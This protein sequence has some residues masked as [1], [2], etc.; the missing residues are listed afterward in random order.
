MVMGFVKSITAAGVF[1][2][3]G[4]A[5]QAAD[6]APPPPLPA[7]VEF[8]GN[9]YIRGDVGVA[10]YQTSNWTQPVGGLSPGDQLQSAGFIATSIREPAFV[11]IGFGY[12][13]NHWF[14]A[15]VTA[16]YRSSV[17]LRGV[18]QETVF[19]PNCGGR[20]INCAFLGQNEYPGS[21][22]SSVFMANGYADLGTWYGLTPYIGAGAGVSRLATTDY[23]STLAPPFTPGLSNTQWRFAWALMG[24]FAYTVTPNL[25]V[26]LGYRYMDFGD[27]DTASDAAGAM[28]LKNL[29][30]HEVRVGVRWSFDDPPHR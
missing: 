18:F 6:L 23:T 21:L 8:A 25:A 4:I 5:A 16:E 12:Q 20:G 10:N 19:T 2:L 24:G 14:R 9:W 13:F 1:A 27:V 30:A 15:D 7:P 26:D 22:Q 17:S 3:S 11:D 29:A 28:T